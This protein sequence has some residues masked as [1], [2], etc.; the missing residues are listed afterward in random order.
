MKIDIDD[1]FIDA[2]LADVGARTAEEYD[3][4]AEHH[5]RYG[6]P[7]MAIRP[8]AC[9]AVLRQ[10]PPER[11]P[12]TRETEWGTKVDHDQMGLASGSPYQLAG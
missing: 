10:R 6:N 7:W 3:A 2:C 5:W 4:S 1:K 11:E 9:A 8:A 12:V